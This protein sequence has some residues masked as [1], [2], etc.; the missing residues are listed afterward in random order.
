MIH[1]GVAQRRRNT[2]KK[3]TTTT[4][5][6]YV[7]FVCNHNNNRDVIGRR[8]K[9]KTCVYTYVC[10]NCTNERLKKRTLCAEYS[11]DVCYVSID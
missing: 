1:D 5:E 8:L 10:M 3:K 6:E 11:I 9:S 2:A 7:Y 4:I